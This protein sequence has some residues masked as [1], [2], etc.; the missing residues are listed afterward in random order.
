M[1]ETA[2]AIGPMSLV[3]VTAMG[4]RL[5]ASMRGPRSRSPNS[6]LEVILATLLA[7]GTC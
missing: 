2:C 7:A 4:E 6:T 5:R 3:G 1:A